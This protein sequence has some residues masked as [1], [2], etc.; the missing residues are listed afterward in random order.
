[1]RCRVLRF[2]CDFM[3][4]L[5]DCH[6]KL[7]ASYAMSVAV[8]FLTFSSQ[9]GLTRFALLNFLAWY[10]RYLPGQGNQDCGMER[11]RLELSLHSWIQIY[12]LTCHIIK[13]YANGLWCLT[14]HPHTHT[15][16]LQSWHRRQ[17]TLC[18]FC[19]VLESCWVWLTVFVLFACLFIRLKNENVRRGIRVSIVPSK[20]VCVCAER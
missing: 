15:H 4:P 3:F 11:A 19:T 2:R 7:S 5:S 16:G 17:H 12:V 13:F 6:M 10:C 18:A 8:S 20:C 9:F 14:A 1:M